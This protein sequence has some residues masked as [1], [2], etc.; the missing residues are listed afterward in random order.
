[1]A[2]DKWWMEAV[3]ISGPESTISK[4]VSRKYRAC[5]LHWH[6]SISLG[7]LF[8]FRSSTIHNWP[9]EAD[10]LIQR[11][12]DITIPSTLILPASGDIRM[13]EYINFIPPGIPGHM[14]SFMVPGRLYE[15]QGRVQGRI[16]CFQW[17]CDRAGLAAGF[18]NRGTGANHVL[19]MRVGQGVDPWIPNKGAGTID[20]F[21]LLPLYTVIPPYTVI[22]FRSV[23]H[24]ILLFRPILLLNPENLSTLY[25]YS[26]L[27]VY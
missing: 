14:S 5:M 2:M 18:T 26:A 19:P 16:Q 10:A 23:F 6:F 27:R 24:H 12:C 15:G 8:W 21:T 25:C 13:D 17:E 7:P 20:Y 1:M 3:S 22:I 4:T 11:P 9:W